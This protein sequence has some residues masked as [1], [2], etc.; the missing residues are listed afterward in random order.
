M[1]KR[2]FH[3]GLQAKFVSAFVVLALMLC[4]SLYWIN[5]NNYKDALFS[6][7]GEDARNISNI[8]ASI[9]DGDRISN[10]AS[11]LQKDEAY[12]GA[13]HQLDLIKENAK[14]AYLYVGVLDQKTQDVTYIFEATKEGDNPADIFQLGDVEH[15]DEVPAIVTNAM[16]GDKTNKELNITKTDYGYLASTFTPVFDS[17]GK[18]VA[19]VGLDVSVDKMMNDL[20][21]YL[22]TVISLT[23]GIVLIS[24]ILLW[25]FARIAVVS[26]ISRLT[27]KVTNF[28]TGEQQQSF[29]KIELKT[30][31]E[32]EDLATSFNKMVADLNQYIVNLANVT[33]EKER[34]ATELLVAQNI[35]QNMMPALFPK[36]S[37]RDDIDLYAINLPAKEVGGDFYDFFFVNEEETKICIVIADVSGKGVP[38]ALFMAI[39]KTLIKNQ[40]FMGEDPAAILTKVNQTLAVDNSDN[41]FV[42]VFIGMLDLESGLLEFA[43]AGHNPPIHRNLDGE[44]KFVYP[45]RSLPLAAMEGIQYT[46]EQLNLEKGERIFLYTDGITE[47]TSASGELFGEDRLI[48]VLSEADESTNS[49]E[50]AQNIQRAVEAFA[51]GEAQFDDI[52]MLHLIRKKKAEGRYQIEI[53][54]ELSEIEHVNTF[55]EEIAKMHLISS[56]RLTKV[57]ICLDE[58][59]SNIIR[60]GYNGAKGKTIKVEC[61]IEEDEIR[62][63]IQD[64]GKPFNPLKRQT[65][66]VTLSAKDRKIGGLGIFLVKEIMDKVDYIYEKQ[67]NSLTMQMKYN[68]LEE[69]K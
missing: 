57:Q 30:G 13:L 23:I 20:N 10:Y 8:A 59:L 37:K 34:I 39:S 67:Q 5:Y 24:C 28:I 26:P 56:E 29:E 40:A 19:L 53:V 35:Q 47:A 44:C 46:L 4:G 27:N 16:K 50:I 38:A 58:T 42:T 2:K 22:R 9:L 12:E 48:Q 66:D 61:L 63:R 31:D 33:S 3:F 17:N 14:L 21:D 49:E 52:T 18:V 6:K 7:H 55:F 43:S 51:I 36:F 60:Y 41:M 25:Q 68:P 1:K 65:P 45:Q 62:I 69:N 11:T 32:I 15:L 64:D 54:N